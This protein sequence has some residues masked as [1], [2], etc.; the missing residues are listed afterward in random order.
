MD[1]VIAGC[2]AFVVFARKQWYISPNKRKKNGDMESTSNMF[3]RLHL[4]SPTLSMP[5]MWPSL[6]AINSF[7]YPLLM[8][9]D[10]LIT[11]VALPPLLH[12]LWA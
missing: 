9:V 5:I 7:I 6:L 4:P 11:A 12:S 8:S 3:D 2:I 1:L 10:V